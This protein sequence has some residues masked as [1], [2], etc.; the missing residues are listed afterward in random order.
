MRLDDLL[1][2]IGLYGEYPSGVDI[3][4]MALDSRQV[5]DGSLFLAI[6]GSNGH[7][8]DY[9]DEAITNGAVAVL[10]DQWSGEIPIDIPAL[11]VKGLRTH[12]GYLAN[13]FYKYPCQGL[14]IIGV[15]GTNGK[16]TTVHLIAQLIER[17]G[18]KVARIGTLGVSVGSHKLVSL[19][20]TTPD[21]V[22]L[23]KIFSELQ[24]LEVQVVAMEVS[25]HAL[26]QYRVHGIPFE[27]AVMTNLTRDHLDYHGDMDSYGR[28]KA[29]L[30]CDFNIRYAV[31]NSDDVFCKKLAD[32]LSD[33]EV[34]T[35]GNLANDFRIHC[36]EPTST[37]SRIGLSVRGVTSSIELPLL[38]E[39]NVQNVLAAVGAVTAIK[40]QSTDDVLALLNQLEVVPGR[41][42]CFKTQESATVVVDYA[43]TPDAL[44]KALNTC[45][46]HC[47]GE[48]WSVFGCGG[49]RDSGKRPLMGRIASEL[50]DHVVLTSDNPRF[51]SPLKIIGEIRSGMTQTPILEE[52]DRSK[53]IQFAVKTAKSKDYILLAGKGHENYQIIGQRTESFSDRIEVTRLLKREDRGAQHAS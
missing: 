46:S 16:T 42:E 7:G 17:L 37:G 3:I 32:T 30:F 5:T 51:E 9:I 44:E 25:S 38:G 23:F 48:I 26:D 39:F 2:K 20:R 47:P 21:A 52:V 8:L 15:T 33:K 28:A 11:K 1:S 43:H 29:R 18:Y 4:D 13:I 27:V 6:Q 40:P 50:S 49:G 53:A 22:S 41:M 10:Y 24:S 45:R 34:V 36:I 35:F 31:L 19:D 12:I 14:H